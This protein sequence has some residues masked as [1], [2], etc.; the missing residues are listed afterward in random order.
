VN[1]AAATDRAAGSAMHRRLHVPACV[2]L[3]VYGVAK[4]AELADWKRLH[5]DTVAMLGRGSGTVTGLL[6]AGKGAEL[7]LTVLAVL[8]LTR[9]SETLLLTALA[10]WTV[11]LA[12]LAT[13][14]AIS[15][16]RGRMLEHGLAFVAFAALLTVTYA[17]GQVRA[18]DVVRTVLRRRPGPS[19][20][21][22]GHEPEH[23][24]EPDDTL[25]G[26]GDATRHDLRTRGSDMT[27]LDLP[28]RGPDV[29]RQDLP[30]RRR[31]APEP[32]RNR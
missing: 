20:V 18:G 6:A 30:V 16:D 11:D 15:G 8:A 24:H 5:H 4:L 25:Q 31:P 26:L 1:P 13:V 21:D 22:P 10:G 3:I 12:L 17:Y 2:F 28:A 7:I 23:E 29:T 19:S 9:R 14:A 32:P 27:R